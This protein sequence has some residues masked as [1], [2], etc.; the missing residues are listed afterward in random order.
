MTWKNATIFS[1]V[2]V[3]GIH[4]FGTSLHAQNGDKFRGRLAPVPALGIA[5]AAVQGVGSATA[6][7]N[8]RKLT[9]SGSF[10]KLASA[11]TAAHLCLGPIT[12]VRGDS[13]FDLTVSKAGDGTSGTVAGAFDLNP[14][15]IDAL[16]KG[17]FYIQI[18]SEG[19]P[20]GHLMGWLLK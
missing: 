3:I 18:H 7:L 6:T 8:G 14:Q 13:V 5:P 1:L 17:R 11:A 12:G 9:V 15:Q 2:I 20:N 19:A 16:K 10:E 4:W